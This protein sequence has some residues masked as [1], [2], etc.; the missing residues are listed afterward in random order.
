MNDTSMTVGAG[1]QKIS[2][3]AM[4]HLLM[5]AV[6]MLWGVMFA[7]IKVAIDVVRTTVV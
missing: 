7:L 1:S 5:L 3:N 2:R 4:A 6:V